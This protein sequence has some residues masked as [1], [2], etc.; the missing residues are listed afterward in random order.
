MLNSNIKTK[1]GGELEVH[2]RAGK[3]ILSV[4]P[5]GAEEPIKISLRSDEAF[6]LE[7]AVSTARKVG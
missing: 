1:D 2:A 7:S 6:E 3:V 4:K 5:L